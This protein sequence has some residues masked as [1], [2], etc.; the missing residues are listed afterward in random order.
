MDPIDAP[1]AAR[2]ASPKE[3]AATTRSHEKTVRRWCYRGQ[4][5]CHRTPGGLIR[6]EVDATGWPLTD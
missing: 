4:V 3:V 1:P 2:Y 5:R 6:V